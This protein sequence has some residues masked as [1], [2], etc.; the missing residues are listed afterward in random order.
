[1]TSEVLKNDNA[2]ADRVGWILEFEPKHGL[3]GKVAEGVIKLFKGFVQH[4]LQQKINESLPENFKK[5]GTLKVV[6]KL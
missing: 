1:M 4:K 6:P 2:T 5:F 3:S